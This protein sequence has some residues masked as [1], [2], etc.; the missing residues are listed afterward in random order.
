MVSGDWGLG[1]NDCNQWEGEIS[2][3][4]DQAAAGLEG[5]KPCLFC[6]CVGVCPAFPVGLLLSHSICRAC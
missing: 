1:G 5:G 2:A 3:G 6:R 4:A